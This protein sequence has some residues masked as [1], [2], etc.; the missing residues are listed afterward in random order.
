MTRSKCG[1]VVV[2]LVRA[3][4]RQRRYSEKMEERT[5][6][7]VLDAVRKR[8]RRAESFQSMRYLS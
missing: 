8:D 6:I 5:V 1:R 7:A 4:R 2:G 3:A